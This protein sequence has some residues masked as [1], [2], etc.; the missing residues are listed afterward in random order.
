MII[1]A[2]C[3]V[4]A[5]TDTLVIQKKDTLV[6]LIPIKQLHFNQKVTQSNAIASFME[7]RNGNSIINKWL[8]N[9]LLTKGKKPA[10]EQYD[11]NH[12]E[13]MNQFQG[14]TIGLITVKRLP[15]FGPSI[16]DTISLPSTWAGRTGNKLRIPTNKNVIT[17]S[18]TFQSG[19][20]F[21]TGA[22]L[23]S[24]R[25]L[26]NLE[27]IND[28][29]IIVSP[30]KQNHTQIDIEIIV[31][32]NY[33]HAISLD[34]GS[35]KP[36]VSIYTRNFV[37]YGIFFNQTLA[38][39]ATSWGG[40]ED[41]LRINN[42]RGSRI[43]FELNYIDNNRRN[44]IETLIERNYYISDHKYGGGLYF[45]RSYSNP[46]NQVLN[47]FNWPN[48]MNYQLSSVWIGKKMTPN[49]SEYL[50]D[51]HLYIALQH[52]RSRFY[53]IPDSL[54]GHPLLQLNNSYFGSLSFGK[55]KYFKNSM[56][57]SFGRTEDIP[58]GFL[59]SLTLGINKSQYATRPYLGF[60]FSMGHAVIPNKGY[61]YVG[62]GWENYFNKNHIEQA[63][64]MGAL[65]YITP[66]LKI[67][68]SMLRT[69]VEVNYTKGINRFKDESLFINEKQNGVVL[70]F[71]N[72]IKGTE[73][74]VV[75][76]ENVTFTP[77]QFWGFNM[78]LFSF[79]DV[80]WINYSSRSLFDRDNNFICVGAG[81][82]IRNERLVFKT[83]ELRFGFI[84][85]KKYDQP[86]EFKFSNGSQK[87][88]DD[89]L[90]SAPKFN[91][92]K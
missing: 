52:T 19:D 74:I 11:A 43:D 12:I 14:R 70:F 86:F 59:T 63:T 39:D 57:Y 42:I 65:K 82:K 8:K 77:V 71:D 79:A 91:L 9:L 1:L 84:S 85:G 20:R 7:T 45:N 54:L 48:E 2:C 64:L 72:N 26:R 35:E 92:F 50:E 25:I 60:T 44:W 69:F 5:Q 6:Y 58:Y 36:E 13:S 4:A 83:L 76:I 38:S 32:D 49:T 40:I 47:Q 56:V 34:L 67:N 37:G 18:I 21:N 75:N 10:P 28:A 31:Q 61:L 73:K 68:G 78:A 22:L 80:A 53:E 51:A 89:F 66:L 62:G 27:W 88:F 33:P 46:A 16:N 23:E 15:P 55:R 87:R 29:R 41:N 30:S 3:S 81:I 90:P 24:E 17:N